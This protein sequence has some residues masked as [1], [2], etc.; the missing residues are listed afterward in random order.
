M[1]SLT[2]A[3]TPQRPIGGKRTLQCLRQ[4][5]GY[6]SAKDFAE[7]LGI[8]MSTYT[9]YERAGVGAD[10]GIPLAAAWQIADALGCSIDLVVGREDIDTPAPQ[11]VQPRYNVLSAE[12]RQLVDSYLAFVEES[13]ASRARLAGGR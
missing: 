11:G 5:A 8:P 2:H 6:R 4:K 12:G 10:C 13:E 9:R 7:V 1:S 3:R